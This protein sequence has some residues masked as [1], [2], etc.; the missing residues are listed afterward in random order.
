MENNEWL[1]ELSSTYLNNSKTK[2]PET[3]LKEDSAEDPCEDAYRD[4][5]EEVIAAGGD[6]ETHGGNERCKE[7]KRKCE[8][9]Q[10]VKE[11]TSDVDFMVSLL[12]GIQEQVGEE[13]TDEEIE[14]ILETVT[15][16]VESMVK[17]MKN[18]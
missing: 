3:P 1:K 14:T 17:K 4:C 18:K 16:V 15:T 10:V 2:T 9:M 7:K 13:L 5:I 11:E 6:G 8:K 12:E